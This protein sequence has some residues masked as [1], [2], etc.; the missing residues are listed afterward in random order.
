MLILASSKAFQACNPAISQVTFSGVR[1]QL[2]KFMFSEGKRLKKKSMFLFQWFTLSLQNLCLPEKDIFCSVF[3][4][5]CTVKERHTPF[6]FKRD[7]HIYFSI[8]NIKFSEKTPK[9]CGVFNTVWCIFCEILYGLYWIFS[10]TGFFFFGRN[11]SH[12]KFWPENFFNQV[13][14]YHLPYYFPAPPI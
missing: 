10:K 12:L 8:E 2:M 3:L 7:C 13:F 4:I 9:T 1:W 5:L 11:I 6:T 14:L